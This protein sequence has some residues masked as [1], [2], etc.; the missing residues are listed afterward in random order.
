LRLHPHFLVAQVSEVPPVGERSIAKTQKAAM[1]IEERIPSMTDADLHNLKANAARL[2]VGGTIQ[3]QADAQRL[4]P[5]IAA[6]VDARAVA[7]ALALQAKRA[8]QREAR[9]AARPAS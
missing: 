3:Q 7:R 8:A 9:Q 5:A 1:H 6:E 2:A 4:L